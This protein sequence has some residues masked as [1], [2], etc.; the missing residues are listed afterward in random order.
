MTF[1]LVYYRAPV[2]AANVTLFSC[3]HVLLCM[4]ILVTVQINI[5]SFIQHYRA[6]LL[7][8]N[9]NNKR[10]AVYCNYCEKTGK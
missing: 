6:V 7:G 5:H 10:F 8:L 4:L 2:S 3:M 1:K 9:A